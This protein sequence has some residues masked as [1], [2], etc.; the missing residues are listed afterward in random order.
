MLRGGSW[1]YYNMSQRCADREYNTAV[2]PGY[3]YLGIRVAL[4]DAGYKKLIKK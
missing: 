1:G 2:Y 4:S 3:I